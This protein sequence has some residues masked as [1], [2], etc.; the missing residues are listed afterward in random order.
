MGG[1]LGG[2]HNGLAG[3]CQA[4]IH[5]QR[6]AGVGIAVKAGE[7][8]AGNI[9]PQAVAGGAKLAGRP[10]VNGIFIDLP[11]RDKGRLAGGSAVAGADD[12]ILQVLGVAVGPY[13]D[14]F[15]GKVGVGSAAGGEQLNLDGAG[16]FQIPREGFRGID[17]DLGAAFRRAL[18]G[19]AVGNHQG[20]AA[21]SERRVVRVIDIFIG[22]FIRRRGD[23]REAAIAAQSV[24]RAAGMEVPGDIVGA[25][26]RP[27][28]FVAPAVFAHYKDIDRRFIHNSGVNI[29]QPVVEPAAEVVV[30]FN[31]GGRAEVDVPGV[32]G[33]GP[34]VGADVRPGADQQFLAAA[35]P[36]AAAVGSKGGVGVQ[37]AL[38][39]DVVPGTDMEQG[40]FDAGQVFQQVQPPPVGAVQFLVKVFVE[41]G[42][43]LFKAANPIPQRQMAVPF[44][45][46]RPAEVARFQD[47][48]VHLRQQT[49]T[50]L[51]FQGVATLVDGIGYH[52]TPFQ[53]PAGMINPA[54][55][56]VGRGGNGSHSLQR[57]RQGIVDGQGVLGR[58]QVGL[59]GSSDPS[60]APGLAGGPFHR[61]V[62]VGDFLKEGLVIVAL[63]ME[64]GAAILAQH[65]IAVA[66]KKPDGMVG[67]GDIV[68]LAVR[69]PVD[70][71]G[72]A[73]GSVGSEKVGS[74]AGTIP[75]RHHNIPF[76][77]NLVLPFLRRHNRKDSRNGAGRQWGMA[78]KGN[79]RIDPGWSKAG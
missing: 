62:A 39:K 69:P 78:G 56:K 30:E 41:I 68:I 63:G 77:D 47:I 31:G 8:A 66:G 58:A 71:G 26:Q 48:V 51:P 61:V 17:Q 34:G 46:E 65:Y 1:V 53:R 18:V 42:G 28:R 59:A 10:Q 12:A 29:F 19:D 20:I 54:L 5:A 50:A 6:R 25:G 32:A 16:D 37:R 33:S 45:L 57:R 76:P 11:R 36:F 43:G 74:Q 44:L 2:V 7:V 23:G 38:Q 9:H 73:A 15:G 14:Q 70:Q 55:M 60:V 64:P 67:A 21:Q 52:P 72:K 24:G 40:D 27:L 35:G 49:L 75:H 4:V 22:R 79:Q 13:Q 3:G